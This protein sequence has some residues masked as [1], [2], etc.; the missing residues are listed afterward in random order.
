MEVA[1]QFTIAEL[2]QI[3]NDARNAIWESGNDKWLPTLVQV[4]EAMI[5]VLERNEMHSRVFHTQ[6]VYYNPANG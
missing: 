5:F 2:D 1:P 6:H 3:A 4:C